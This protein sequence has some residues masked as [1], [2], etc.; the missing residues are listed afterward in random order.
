MRGDIVQLLESLSSMHEALPGISSTAE[1][2]GVVVHARGPRILEVEAV[3]SGGALGLI[4]A[5]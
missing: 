1:S 2:W 5:T 4:L 3:G